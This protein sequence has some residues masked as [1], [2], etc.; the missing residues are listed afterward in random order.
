ML[1]TCF[2]AVLA[3]FG[4]VIV[5]TNTQSASSVMQF[6]GRGGSSPKYFIQVAV[7]PDSE[8]PCVY[9]PPNTTQ[10]VRGVC[11]G[12]YVALA[13]C[14]SL[15]MQFRFGICAE[16]DVCC[17]VPPNA[18]LTSL[19]TSSRSNE[20]KFCGTTVDSDQQD[21]LNA[22]PNLSLPPAPVFGITDALANMVMGVNSETDAVKS[23]PSRFARI[24]GGNTLSDVRTQCWIAAI[25][26][27]NTL[28]GNGALVSDEWVITTATTVRRF[29]DSG[30]TLKIRLG[31]EDLNGGDT[32]T[33]GVQRIVFH[34]EFRMS[35]VGYPVTDVALLQLDQAMDSSK[36]P[37]SCT[38]CLPAPEQSFSGADCNIAGYGVTSQNSRS[39]DGKLRVVDVR[40][41]RDTVCA[42][43]IR[44]NLRNPA[45]SLSSS[46]ICA[47]GVRGKDSC[48]VRISSI[49][50]VSQVMFSAC[51]A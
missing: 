1:Q 48:T 14:P 5:L 36:S 6:P 24:L 20:R 39:I 44:N 22:G 43:I 15:K 37:S 8:A 26:S 18:Q 9:T 46:T 12:V 42:N 32:T 16:G 25:L 45:F 23:L 19:S 49:G 17:F 29:L 35:R 31:Q 40:V 33:Y 47:G 3:V 50:P 27:E 38:M 4:S 2:L 21:I 34:P 11:F 41:Y 13:Y 28:V 10:A 7:A 51:T 30:S